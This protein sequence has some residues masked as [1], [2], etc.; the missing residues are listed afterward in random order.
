MCDDFL[1]HLFGIFESLVPPGAEV[2]RVHSGSVRQAVEGPERYSD[3]R[4]GV[5]DIEEVVHG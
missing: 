3:A 2:Q 1:N 5:G 4:R